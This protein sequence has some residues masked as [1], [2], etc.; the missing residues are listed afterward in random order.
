MKKRILVTGAS[1]LLGRHVV[2]ALADTG[3]FEITAVS[4]GRRSMEYPAGVRTEQADLLTASAREALFQRIQ[5]D[6][7]CHYAW[8]LA[9]SGFKYSAVNLEWLEASFHILRLFLENGGKHFFFAGSSSE[10]GQ[11]SSGNKEL[12]DA[13]VFSLYGQSKKAFE[14]TA[15]I[16]CRENNI[17]FTAGR[18]F[19]VYGPWDIRADAALPTSIRRMLAGKKF[20]CT[21]PENLWDFVYVEDCALATVRLLQNECRGSY[22]IATGRP[23]R[24]REVF[25]MIAEELG[26]QHLLEFADNPGQILLTAD[27]SKLFHETGYV[28]GTDMRSGIRATVEWWKE[29]ACKVS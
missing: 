26:T 29:Y 13:P 12:P 16:F 11:G 27:V 20:V 5:P 2:K 19:S 23:V 15:G 3:E 6:I 10:Y 8:T 18:Y 25:G 28:C 22:N 7:C 1:G 9:D 14:E 17:L 24:M 4:S 21:S